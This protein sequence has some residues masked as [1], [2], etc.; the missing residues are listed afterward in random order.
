MGLAWAKCGPQRKSRQSSGVSSSAENGSAKGG[1]V[2]ASKAGAFCWQQKQHFIGLFLMY[3]VPSGI[4]DQ[5]GTASCQDGSSA[6]PWVASYTLHQL[7]DDLHAPKDVMVLSQAGSALKDHRNM[8]LVHKIEGRKGGIRQE[9]M[10]DV[11]ISND[12]NK[13]DSNVT[14]FQN[15]SLFGVGCQSVLGMIC[16]IYR[17]CVWPNGSFFFF[18]LPPFCFML[19]GCS[20]M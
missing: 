3:P 18:H 7:W 14:F 16:K 8:C 10:F 12:K 9:V 11:F 20:C 6:E 2:A 5:S 19:Q 4:Q 15:R 17:I 13:S 1:W